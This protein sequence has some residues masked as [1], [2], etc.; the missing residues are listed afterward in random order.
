MTS[1]TTT[2]VSRYPSTETFADTLTEIEN[3]TFFGRET[4]GDDLLNQILG[5]KFIVL[6]GASGLGKT[7]LLQAKIS[8]GLRKHKLLPLPIRVRQAEHQEKVGLLAL[9]L[10]RGTEG[11]Q[12]SRYRLYTR[13]QDPSLGVL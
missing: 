3:P 5:N 10:G 2:A 7:S 9:L 1:E 8:P 4:E 13:K 11:L 12:G 6:Y